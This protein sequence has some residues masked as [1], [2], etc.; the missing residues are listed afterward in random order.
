MSST[1]YTPELNLV[2]TGSSGPNGLAG[3]SVYSYP[4]GSYGYGLTGDTGSILFTPRI[5]S[6]FREGQIAAQ[7]N[8][9]YGSLLFFSINTH[10]L[11][12]S[13]TSI[14]EQE[15]GYTITNA[16]ISGMVSIDGDSLPIYKSFV[17]EY[18]DV[19]YN[20]SPINA[21]IGFNT[22][23]TDATILESSGYYSLNPS[24]ERG[25]NGNGLYSTPS[26]GVLTYKINLVTNGSV[27]ISWPT[28]N[29]RIKGFIEFT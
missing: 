27:S 17:F 25:F 19:L 6:F 7:G 10:E 26:G 2:P 15:V 8:Y 1:L 14:T 12:E 23:V 24:L 13:L 4:T 18:Y 22:P 3:N 28:R 21:Q 16:K 5:F 9:G 29:C 20:L 11:V